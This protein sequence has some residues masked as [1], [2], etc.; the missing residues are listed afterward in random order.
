MEDRPV[1]ERVRKP[2][3]PGACPHCGSLD[4]V[5]HRAGKA[6]LDCGAVYK[7]GEVLKSGTVDVHYS[8]DVQD[9]RGATLWRDTLDVLF[10]AQCDIAAGLKIPPGS[11]F[12]K[13]LRSKQRREGLIDDGDT[14]VAM[15]KIVGKIMKHA[16]F[17]RDEY[18]LQSIQRLQ[19][20]MPDA[21]R[22]QLTLAKR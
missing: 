14:I 1:V 4:G 20:V 7:D 21:C 2:V 5:E 9:Y 6:C 16:R 10:D 13:W 19:K 17:V 8:L 15:E 3:Y 22:F 12:A 18:K 11:S